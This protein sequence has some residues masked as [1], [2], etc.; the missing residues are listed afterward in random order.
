MMKVYVNGES[1]DFI[2][3]GDGTLTLSQAPGWHKTKGF[4]AFLKR[5]FCQ[6]PSGWELDDLQVVYEGM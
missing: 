3:N 1:V 6:W 4:I 2:D 5:I